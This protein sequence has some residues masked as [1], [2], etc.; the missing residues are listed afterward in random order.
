MPVSTEPATVTDPSSAGDA[1]R[2]V[3]SD[4][5]SSATWTLASR[6]TGL[7]RVLA[8]GAVFGP[9]YVGNLFHLANQ[10]P[11]LVFEITVGSLLGSLLVPALMAHIGDDPGA[12]SDPARLARLAGGLTTVVVVS[13]GVVSAAVMA[14][15]PLLSRVFALGVPEAVHADLVAA[16]IP[17]V[18][19][20]APQLV[21]YGL[22]VTAQSIQQAMGRFALPAAA[23]MAENLIV[24]GSLVLYAV[25]FETETEVVQLDSSRVLLLGLGSSAGVAAHVAVQWWGVHRLGLGL[26]PAWGFNDPEIRG[27]LR[28]AVAAMGTASLN[29]VRLFV[30][31][32]AANSLAG[33]VVA[34]QLGLN[35]VGVAV[36]LGAK[37][38]AYAVLPRLSLRFRERDL[39]AYRDDYERGV[40]LAA[41]IVIPAAAGAALL[42]WLL[43]PALAIGEMSESNG[44][45]LLIVTVT[46]V[47]GA[48]LGESLHQ[49]A[50]AAC[51]GRDDARSPLIAFVVRL[52][53]TLGF[54]ALAMR[55]GGEARLGWIV[56][57]MSIGDVLSALV[58]HGWAVRDLPR[59][60]DYRLGRSVARTLGA[61]LVG[62]G[63]AALLARL[64]LGSAPG[65]PAELAMLAAAALV[66]A[67]ISFGIRHR[68]DDEM[69]TLVGQLRGGAA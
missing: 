22:T 30:L 17:L 2:S 57:A 7:V 65:R 31:L 56:A 25:V 48:V 19:L 69:G 21:G 8:V 33:G 45:A 49:L 5:A 58:L 40:G 12:P 24:V 4:S 15:A 29:G 26:R 1:R 61:V 20:T 64:V 55:F 18:L 63:P 39:G 32:V 10:L 35:L 52:G 43:G 68:L 11:W 6:A 46:M 28:R 59:T 34:L 67:V 13:F 54:I 60:G 51:Y 41:L 47:A 3:V 16:G 37:P 50:V 23:G 44:R 9:T 66:G 38:V 36:A 42:G 27:L 53:I 14:L 62:F